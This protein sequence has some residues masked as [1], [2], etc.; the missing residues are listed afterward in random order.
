MIHDPKPLN[1]T[2]KALSLNPKV[3]S[4]AHLQLP[5]QDVLA[6]GVLGLTSTYC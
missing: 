2:K 1:L 4:T 5:Q 3:L 6:T